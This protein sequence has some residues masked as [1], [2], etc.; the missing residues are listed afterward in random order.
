MSEITA[1]R[2]ATSDIVKRLREMASV[3]PIGESIEHN[4]TVNQAADLIEQQQAEI[5][6][7]NQ[8]RQVQLGERYLTDL[9]IVRGERDQLKAYAQHKPECKIGRLK[10]PADVG[11]GKYGCTC[12]L[13]ELLGE[14]DNG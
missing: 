8:Y 10:I 5:D 1:R 14:S 9:R 12:G 2:K 3:Y 11:S 6:R 13:A 7:L 4:S